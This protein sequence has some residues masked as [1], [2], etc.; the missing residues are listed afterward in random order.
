MK[1]IQAL[2]LLCFSFVLPL[3]LAAQEQKAE[4]LIMSISENQPRRQVYQ[5][6]RQ[7]MYM[8]PSITPDLKRHIYDKSVFRRKNIAFLLGRFKF[9]KDKP[10]IDL[11]VQLANDTE[12]AVRISA[13]G[14][15]SDQASGPAG[16][17]HALMTLVN[18]TDDV[19]T[20]VRREAF[21][22]LGQTAR[23]QITP[24]LA[25]KLMLEQNPDV[26]IAILRGLADLSDTNAASVFYKVLEQGAIREKRAAIKGLFRLRDTSREKDIIAA[27]DYNDTLLSKRILQLLTK[28]LRPRYKEVFRRELKNPNPEISVYAYLGL[29]A[30]PDTAYFKEIL[31]RA[32]TY[33]T[34]QMITF[35]ANLSR[36]GKMP[37]TIAFLTA[38]LKNSDNWKIRQ[39]AAMSLGMLKA[40]KAEY[41]LLAALQDSNNFVKSNVVQALGQ[42]KSKRAVSPLISI[43]NENTNIYLRRSIVVALGEIG[44]SR[45]LPFLRSAVKNKDVWISKDAKKSIQEI[46][47]K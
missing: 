35:V 45:A 11:L 32:G 19:D 16:D 25:G 34:P 6:L 4:Q 39:R 31:K 36:F 1:K 2:L 7:L 29:A 28:N 38:R 22:S 41:A 27:L 9:L 12:P 20:K 26:R 10:S 18:M 21:L 42:I 3:T 37:N 15:L 33:K 44:D 43:F 13:A 14:A 47:G 46:E 24:I 30:Y 17:V 40:K 8:G 5:A 23:K